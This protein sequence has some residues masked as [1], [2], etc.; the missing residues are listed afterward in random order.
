MTSSIARSPRGA[1]RRATARAVSCISLGVVAWTAGCALDTD[2]DGVL[3]SNAREQFESSVQPL[4]EE[5]C[6]NP[7]CHGNAERALSL[8]AVHQHRLDA[9]HVYMD[10]P[11]T[12]E[13]VRHNY[14]RASA[15]LIGISDVDVSP[16]LRKPLAPDAGGVAH[17]GETQ[18][19]DTETFGYRVLRD[20][21]ARAMESTEEGQ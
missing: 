20:W 5:R 9:D 3:P 14:L 19:P 11:L 1:L 21:A 13:E 6:S 16:L 2:Y 4:L 12:D 15:F 7:T 17:R 18:F 10:A 8:Y